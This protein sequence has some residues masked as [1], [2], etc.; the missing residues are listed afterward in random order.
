MSSSV[1]SAVLQFGRQVRAAMQPL[2]PG[3]CAA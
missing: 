3:L 1:V 2:R